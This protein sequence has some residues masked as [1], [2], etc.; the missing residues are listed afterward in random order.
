VARRSVGGE[1]LM[2]LTVDSSVSAELLSEAAAE[3]GAAA[4]SAVDLRDD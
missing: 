1:A 2:T 3:I 4:A